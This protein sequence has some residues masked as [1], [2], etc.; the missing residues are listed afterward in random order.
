MVSRSGTSRCSTPRTS[1][2]AADPLMSTPRSA[3]ERLSRDAQVVEGA[4][5]WSR[6]CRAYAAGR[7]ARGA[8]TPDAD[9]EHAEQIADA[10]A[11]LEVATRPPA[12]GAAWDDFVEWAAD[13]R[14]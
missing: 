14:T 10:V 6:R 11:E 7:L 12:D 5:Q 8:R 2:P 9:A 1:R 13:L 3:W 4:D